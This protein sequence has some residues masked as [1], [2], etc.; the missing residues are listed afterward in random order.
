[1]TD[2]ISFTLT[3]NRKNKNIVYNDIT[4]VSIERVGDNIKLSMPTKQGKVIIVLLEKDDLFKVDY[5]PSTK[6]GRL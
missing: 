1:M 3:I 6:Q 2:F 5:M 4:G